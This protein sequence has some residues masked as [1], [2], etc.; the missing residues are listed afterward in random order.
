MGSAAG[1]VTWFAPIAVAIGVLATIVLRAI[2]LLEFVF[3]PVAV[4]VCLFEHDLFTRFG[5]SV[6][7]MFAVAVTAKLL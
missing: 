5:H 3:W 2:V 7:A 6:T 4:I 1:V